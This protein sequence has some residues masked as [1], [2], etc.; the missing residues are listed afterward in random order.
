MYP[1]NHQEYLNLVLVQDILIASLNFIIT[2]MEW[3]YYP[4]RE[5]IIYGLLSVPLLQ[6]LVSLVV[7]LLKTEFLK[8]NTYPAN[9]RRHNV[10]RSYASLK[11]S[12]LLAATVVVLTFHLTVRIID[13][14][15]SIRD[16]GQDRTFDFLLVGGYIL[17]AVLYLNFLSQFSNVLLPLP[18]SR[19]RIRRTTKFG[20]G[21]W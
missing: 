19:R 10:L 4:G 8:N 3:D 5:I 7:L 20:S 9:M 2:S 16:R 15:Q 13:L 6:V 21:L 17:Y 12:V 1:G 14:V 11:N 18:S